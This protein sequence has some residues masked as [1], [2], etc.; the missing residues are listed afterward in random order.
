MIFA[1]IFSTMMKSC[2]NKWSVQILMFAWV[3]RETQLFFAMPLKKRYIPD[4]VY[5]TIPHCL[6]SPRLFPLDS[7]DHDYP[8][9]AASQRCCPPFPP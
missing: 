1:E 3:F 8:L 4:Y 7:F 5:D 2:D 9:S 6:G